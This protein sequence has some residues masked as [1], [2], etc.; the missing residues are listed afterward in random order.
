MTTVHVSLTAILP[1]YLVSHV[2]EGQK[3]PL[4]DHSTHFLPLL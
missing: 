4:L 2:K 3:V 1:Y